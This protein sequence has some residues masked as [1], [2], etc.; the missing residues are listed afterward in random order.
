MSRERIAD[1]GAVILFKA[2]L[3]LAQQ[4]G[5]PQQENEEVP[6]S[7]DELAWEEEQASLVPS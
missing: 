3:V 6:L 5:T 7:L 4:Q 1:T 2:L